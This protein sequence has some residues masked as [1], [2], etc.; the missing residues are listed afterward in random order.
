MIG[1]NIIKSENKKS[2]NV[3]GKQSRIWNLI[4]GVVLIAFFYCSYQ[5]C[6]FV[7]GY[8]AARTEYNA[9]ETDFVQIEPEKSVAP[10]EPKPGQKVKEE[11][12]PTKLQVDINKLKVINPDIVAWI[13]FPNAKISYPVMHTTDNNYYLTHTYK[14]TVMR[15]GSIFIDCQNKGDFSDK[16][17]IIYGHNMKDG[18]MFGKLKNY[19]KKI[20]AD[21]NQCFYILTKNKMYRC[22]VFSTYLTS[23]D[24]NTYTYQF[25][26]QLSYTKYLE[27]IK[28]QAK[29]TS[30]EQVTAQDNIVTLSTC[31]GISHDYRQVVQGKLVDVTKKSK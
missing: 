19:N 16:N 23:A 8:Y 3:R 11:K 31:T 18:S 26:S 15:V 24:S 14:K 7:W 13:Y 28:K 30:D 22:D 6:L 4:F 25:E 9:L 27:M 12:N 2:C 10:N 17:T 1:R 20:F 29:F 5:I 21:N